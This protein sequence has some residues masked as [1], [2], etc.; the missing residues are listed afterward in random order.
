M[1]DPPD[2]AFAGPPSFEELSSGLVSTA[3]DVLRF[4]CALA[5]G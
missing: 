2:G 5:D 1:L 4:L 3:P